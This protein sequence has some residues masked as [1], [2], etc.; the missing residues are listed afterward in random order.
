MPPDAVTPT[1][2]YGNPGIARDGLRIGDTVGRTP[3]AYGSF[4]SC[5]LRGYV[6]PADV[7]AS[8]KL[9]LTVSSVT[10]I[11]PL[12]MN[13]TSDAGVG[14]AKLRYDMVR[15][16]LVLA[17]Q[18]GSYWFPTRGIVYHGFFIPWFG[19]WSC[20]RRC[21]HRAGTAVWHLAIPPNQRLPSC[22][23]T[24]LH[25]WT[26]SQRHTVEHDPECRC[27]ELLVQNRRQPVPNHHDARLIHESQRYA[28]DRPGR[29]CSHH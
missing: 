4:I 18:T 19:F 14:P 20:R 17:Y 21:V 23:S 26:H 24:L 27:C 25:K 8:A 9:V 11:N 7:I 6:G 10:G 12:T 3:G 13:W 5:D 15:F 2:S 29:Q 16:D 1:G 22:L 28:R